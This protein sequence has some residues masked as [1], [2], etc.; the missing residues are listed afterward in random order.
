MVAEVFDA[1]AEEEED[2][3]GVNAEVR[4]AEGEGEAVELKFDCWELG[5]EAEVVLLDGVLEAGCRRGGMAGDWAVG[6]G[7]KEGC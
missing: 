5:W 7:R 6:M 2:L 1:D 3:V 4:F